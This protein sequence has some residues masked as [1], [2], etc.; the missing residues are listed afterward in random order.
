MELFSSE[1]TKSVWLRPPMRNSSLRT[2]KSWASFGV[3]KRGST[4]VSFA[5]AA[6][7]D[8]ATG[9]S[10]TVVPV[11]RGGRGRSGERRLGSKSPPMA[12][13]VCCRPGRESVRRCDLWVSTCTE[14]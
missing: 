6:E 9:S 8:S 14:G 4:F 13:C 3:T 7:L 5:A 10:P 2:E 1:C 12:G 11:L